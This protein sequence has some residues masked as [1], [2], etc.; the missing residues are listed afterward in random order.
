MREIES[1]PRSV[2]GCRNK[3]SYRINSKIAAVLRGGD[4]EGGRG[5][6]KDITNILTQ[7]AL[8]TCRQTHA[9]SACALKLDKREQS[10]PA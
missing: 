9:E 6:R 10:K 8:K 7:A 1:H 4:G 5:S 3:N 2:A